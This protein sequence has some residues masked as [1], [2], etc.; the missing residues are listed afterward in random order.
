MR[1]LF[2]LT[3]IPCIVVIDLI[4]RADKIEKEPTNE[5]IKAFLMGIVA[6]IITLIVSIILGI[7]KFELETASLLETFIYAFFGIA[8]IEEISKFICGYLFVRKNPNFDYLFDGI[9]YFASVALGFA[10][11]ENILYS[12]SDD[13]GIMVAVIRAVTAIPAHAFFGISS[14]YYYALYRQSKYRNLE[15]SW[16]LL[17]LSILVP[18]MLHGFY[19][20]CIFTNNYIFSIIFIIFVFILYIFSIK[21]VKNMSKNDEL[22]KNKE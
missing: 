10:L 3:V 1:F 22:I 11:I 12:F 14:G 6:I 2:L 13:G 9:V 5:I 16:A 17:V 7:T 19:D 18:I 20:F 8:L 21:R 15:N 4:Y